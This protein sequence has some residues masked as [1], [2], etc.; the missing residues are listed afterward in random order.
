MAECILQTSLGTLRGTE[1]DSCRVFR[2]IPYARTERF[3]LP[4]P[5]GGWE[6]V[7]DATGPEGDV[8]QYA[9]FNAEEGR[10]SKFYY[11]EFRKG[12]EFTFREDLVNLSIVTPPEPKN[13]PVLVFIHG[14]GHETGMVW[15]LPYGGTTEY[16][17][18][19]VVLVSDGY[20]MNVFHMYRARNY[21]LYDQAMAIRWVHE[22]IAD[23]GGDPERI[24]IMGQSAGAMSVMDLCLS[25][26]L[27][28][29]VKGAVMMSGGGLVPAPVGPVREEQC[30]EFWDNVLQRAGLEREEELKTVDAEK[31][32]RAWYAES[33]EHYSF[34]T[35]QP[36]IDG[37]IIPD[38]PQR[39]RARGKILNIPMIVGVTAQ[40]FMPYVIY[41]M[42]YCL[43][44]WSAGRG[45]RAPVYGYLFD[46]VLPGNKYGAFHAADLWYMFGQMEKA[47]RPFEPIDERLKDEM[48]D[49]VANFA[50]YGD[51]TGK[52]LPIWHAV[53]KRQQ[54]FRHF[55]G[56]DD[57]LIQPAAVRKKMAHTW[58]KD[59]GPM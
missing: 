32:W 12:L 13:C 15:E 27:E 6:G 36:G 22:H 53:T 10:E 58:L 11:E 48:I 14:G 26:T 9:T 54:G 33:R 29:V 40:D 38:L 55:D 57:G 23:F 28:G 30:K 34:H 56:V 44:R 41:E 39:L 16:A 37:V 17:R 31:I 52:G 4:Q 8:F 59:P 45:D 21:G 50:R 25:D 49:Y 43:A 24:T 42:A 35:A 18:R 51:P 19:G 47:W 1:D 20:R 46:R 7:L 3:E 5:Y 2:G